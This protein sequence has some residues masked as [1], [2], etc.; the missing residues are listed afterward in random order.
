MIS[1]ILPIFQIDLNKGR[2]TLLDL[3]EEFTSKRKRK[4]KT[5]EIHTSQDLVILFS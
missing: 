2:C 4:A 3:Y 5:V 1:E